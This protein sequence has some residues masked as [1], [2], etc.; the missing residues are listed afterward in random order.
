MRFN[1]RLTKLERRR[2]T[3]TEIRMGWQYEDGTID[4][5]G[6]RITPDEWRQRHPGGE[7]ILLTWGDHDDE[8]T[9]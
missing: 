6:D 5:D 3:Q 8:R 4:D 9:Y 7:L 1:N 2:P